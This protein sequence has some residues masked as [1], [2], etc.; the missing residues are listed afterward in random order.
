MARLAAGPVAVAACALAAARL[1]GPPALGAALAAF[2]VAL[3]QSWRRH[4]AMRALVANRQ[5]M[6]EHMFQAQK[7]AALG[8]LA[9]GIAH[10]INTPLAIIGQ[11][12]EWLEHLLRDEAF[13]ASPKAASLTESLTQ[14]KTQVTRSAEITH[15]ILGF[16]AKR[17]PISQ[18]VDLNRLIEDMVRWIEREASYRNI[19]IV[20]AYQDDL[21]EVETDPPQLRQVVLNLL[22][23]AYQAVDRDGTITVDTHTG[24]NG[25]VAIEVRDT[26]CGISAEN[27]KKIFNPFFT[28]KPPGQGTGLGLAISFSIVNKLGGVLSAASAPGQGATF[29]VTLPVR[30]QTT[31]E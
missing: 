1:A 5:Q 10:E 23:N 18:R 7:L 11:E 3:W 13:A 8:E 9:S 29:T 31:G 2:G 4:T 22:N 14:I 17:A 21:P 6:D 19:S 30:A 26:G 12:A 20:R 27:M 24:P 15:G 28:T 16:A 25:G